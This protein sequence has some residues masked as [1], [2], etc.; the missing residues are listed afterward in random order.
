MR[1]IAS[2]PAG[3]M[4]PVA[5]LTQVPSSSS[6]DAVAPASTCPRL[7]QGSAP[8]T[9]Q[10]STV[11]VGNAGRSVSGL[12]SA[13]SVAPSHAASGSATGGRAAFRPVR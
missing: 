3:T 12:R 6:G 9:A 7:R 5:M 1:T 11:D 8:R 4:A 10:P 2:V 13:A